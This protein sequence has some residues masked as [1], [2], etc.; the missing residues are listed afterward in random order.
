MGSSR[1]KSKERSA[2]D[3]RSEGLG[4]HVDL[5]VLEEEDAYRLL[6][7]RRAPQGPA[8]ERAAREI[9]GELGRYPLAVEIAAAFLAK[10]IVYFTDYL[11][12]LRRDDQDALE[13][14]ASL[15]EALPTGHERSIAATLL[16]SIRQLRP[17]G[18]D[19]LRLAAELA[20]EPIPVSLMREVFEDAGVPQTTDA[21]T[22]ALDQADPLSLCPKPGND[23][24]LVHTLV[25]RTV[26]RY[27]RD[28]ARAEGLRQASVRVLIRR[29]EG[30]V[31][32]PDG[33]RQ[34]AREVARAAFDVRRAG[35]C[36]AGD[37]GVVDRSLSLQE[38]RFPLPPRA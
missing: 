37:S 34:A 16:K 17:E 29:L 9:I 21:L 35:K 18:A 20:V 23:A 14:G 27:W 26:R 11:G 1:R 19:L 3:L 33:R 22:A 6:T 8:Q 10:G 36:R 15:R 5:D 7:V 30:K 31:D 12:E 2:G 38:G 32:D 4:R 28:P 13:Y 24:R 25:S